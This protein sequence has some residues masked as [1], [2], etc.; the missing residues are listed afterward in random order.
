MKK[1]KK[2][3]T[4]NTREDV[5]ENFAVE[6]DQMSDVLLASVFERLIDSWVV[7]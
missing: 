6:Y 7:S 5:D 1:K 2:T 4:T 3:T